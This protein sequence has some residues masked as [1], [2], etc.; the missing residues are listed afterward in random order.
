MVDNPGYL[1]GYHMVE[2]SC[3]HAGDAGLDYVEEILGHQ[4]DPVASYTR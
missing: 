3:F 2:I 1:V 4:D